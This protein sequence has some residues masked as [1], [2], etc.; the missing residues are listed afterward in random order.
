MAADREVIG[1]NNPPGQ[2]D[3]CRET[4]S[5]ISAWATDNPVIETEEK[6]REAKLLVDRAK[7]AA[8]ELEE[9]RD[10]KV[11]PLNEQVKAINASYK[12]PQMSLGSALFV[13]MGR[14]ND[15]IQAEEAKRVAAARAAEEE[16][17]AKI[18]AAEEAEEAARQAAEDA[19][20]GVVV[21]VVA[22]IEEAEQAFKEFAKAERVLAR[23]Q[24]DTHVK[25]G[26]GFNK[27]L[28]QREKEELVVT[29]PLAAIRA[30]GFTERLLET[31]LTEARSFRKQNGCLPIGVIAKKT[32]EL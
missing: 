11:R 27:A 24:K 26:G 30:I 29:D 1:G 22:S 25:I 18:K 31:L 4:T 7:A 6:A 19:K 16:L 15:Y 12:E 23:A 3:F 21:D 8:K 2:I 17:R 13:I 5:A 32:K 20:Q 9:E 14:I 10:K 28:A